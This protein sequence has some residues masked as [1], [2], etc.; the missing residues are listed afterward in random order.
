MRYD[1]VSQVNRASSIEINSQSAMTSKS[2]DA[3]PESAT[4]KT[5]T[6]RGMSQDSQFNPSRSENP[7]SSPVPG[8]VH[9]SNPLQN[10]QHHQEVAAKVKDLECV[11][12]GVVS[13][14]E[15]SSMEL[16]VIKKENDIFKVWDTV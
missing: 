14:Q 2:S 11:V 12:K 1:L 4:R 8:V 7:D 6:C 15:S 9:L 5:S 16:S 13:Q 3:R 10:F